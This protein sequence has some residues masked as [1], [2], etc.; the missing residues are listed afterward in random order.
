VYAW[1]IPF[2][3]MGGLFLFYMTIKGPEH[4]RPLVIAST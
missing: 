3:S 1:E 4:G 2:H